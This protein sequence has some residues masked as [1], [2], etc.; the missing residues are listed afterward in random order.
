M[1]AKRVLYVVL[2][3]LSFVGGILLLVVRQ[4]RLAGLLRSAAEGALI[5]HD[6]QALVVARTQLLMDDST[7]Q[8]EV[9][10]LDKMITAKTYE[11]IATPAR[12]QGATEE[13]INDRLRAHGLLK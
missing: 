9:M 1:T 6:L 7:H 3:A 11:S 8:T 2:A 4:K 10:H 13:D 5:K 12:L